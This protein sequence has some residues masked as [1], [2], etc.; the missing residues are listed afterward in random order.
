MSLELY[1]GS[2]SYITIPETFNDKKVTRIRSGAFDYTEVYKNQENWENGCLYIGDFLYSVSGNV[3]GTFAVKDG[4]KYICDEGFGFCQDITTV[5]IPA[6]VEGIGENAF[7]GCSGLARVYYNGDIESWCSIDFVDASANPFC[8]ADN[9]YIDAN[10]VTEI[11]IPD[12]ITEIK[13][14]AFYDY[15]KLEK[16]TIPDSV[17]KFGTNAFRGCAAIKEVYYEGT[18]AEWCEI[19]FADIYSTPTADL[20]IGGEKLINLTVPAS[21][22]EVLP[23][24]FYGCT[25]IQSVVISDGIEAIS[26]NAFAYCENLS[27][28]LIPDSVKAIGNNAF[29]YCRKL[30]EVSI[31]GSVETIGDSAFYDCWSIDKLSL[32]DG[33]KSIGSSAFRNCDNLVN[34]TIPGTI[35]TISPY[36]FHYCDKLNNVIIKSG[37]KIIGNNA[38]Y[39]CY[40]LVSVT[41]PNTVT[42]IGEN[43]FYNCNSIENIYYDGTQQEWIQLAI[44]TGNDSIVNSFV[45]CEH[46]HYYTLSETVQPSCDQV[47]ARFYTCSCG[48]S[49]SDVIPAPGHTN[50]EWTVQYAPECE[51]EGR[52]TIRCTV[53]GE[54]IESREIPAT[55]HT[56]GEWIVKTEPTET[57]TGLARRTC[58][59]CSDYENKTLAKL[60]IVNDTET[61]VQLV[62]GDELAPGTIM[63]VESVTDNRYF[64]ILSN[65]FGEINSE[66]FNISLYADGAM[67]QP[68]GKV[69]VKIPMPES[70]GDGEFSAC[71]IDALNGEITK[72]PVNVED[73]YIIFETDHFSIYAVVEQLG[74]VEKVSMNDFTMEYKSTYKLNPNITIADDI[75]CKTE[76]KSL[77]PS[78]ATVDKNGNVTATGTGETE[79]TVTVTDEYGNIV[80]DTCKV[81]VSYAWWQWL[82]IIFLFGFI[83]Y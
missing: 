69:K 13:P 8:Y 32:G 5:L 18:V 82:I 31:P 33:I 70:F 2:L 4:T 19:Q 54:V 28:I 68:N 47:G 38:F 25:S 39:N 37:V 46:V 81:T 34:V 27:T 65:E 15:G 72:L 36:A 71:Y 11:V 44:Y 66:V 58:S 51:W 3:T 75:E 80:E 42:T 21:V 50:G 17:T 41:V 77:N 56:W 24:A 61:G 64:Q 49:Y 60:V 45:L 14:Y 67:V 7:Y 20:Y 63:E 59:V 83:W 23:S 9:F 76:Y 16:I 10:L 74:K 53:C 1:T 79:I 26:D 55:G 35:E 73:G 6:S 43:A 40:N 78:V 22:G 30:N 48:D 62:Y 12:T 29:Y 57:S 52:E